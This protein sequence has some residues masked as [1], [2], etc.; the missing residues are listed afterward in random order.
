MLDIEELNKIC[1]E[2]SLQYNIKVTVKITPLDDDYNGQFDYFNHQLLIN[3]DIEDQNFAERII[4]HEFR[5]AWQ[6]ANYPE[7]FQWW[8]THFDLYKH[9]YKTLFNSLERDAFAFGDSSG[10]KNR[11]DLLNFYRVEDLEN[12]LQDNTISFALEHL[13]YLE[14]QRCR[15]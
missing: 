1:K 10:A 4:Y 12:L 11:E 8:M 9:Y 7:L 6:R 3:S 14:S 2:L 13:E 5:H 15:D